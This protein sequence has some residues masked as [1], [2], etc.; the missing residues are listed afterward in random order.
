M[1]TPEEAARLIMPWPPVRP[2]EPAWLRKFLTEKELTQEKINRFITAI[3]QYNEA[4][5]VAAED[6]LIELNKI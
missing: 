1:M 4:C 3:E 2:L 5:K 6:L